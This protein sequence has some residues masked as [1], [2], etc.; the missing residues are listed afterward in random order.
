MKAK[1][2]GITSSEMAVQ[3]AALHPDYMGFVFAKSRRQVEPAEVNTFISRMREVTETLP[4]LVGVFGHTSQE[5]IEQVL[6]RV[7]LDAIQFHFPADID[8]LPAIKQQF[9]VEI[10]LTIPIPHF[11]DEE[12][13]KISIKHLLHLKGFENLEKASSHIDGV[14][15]DTHD[16]VYGGGSGKTFRW[17]LIPLVAELVDNYR[18]PL[19]AAGGLTPSNVAELKQYPLAGVDVSSGVESNGVKDI[20]KVRQFIERVRNHDESRT[21]LSLS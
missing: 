13:D 6:H 1:I 4:K 17:E 8:W 14:L 18:L 20:D 15:L 2:C 7:K 3:I 11:N 10:W 19:F 9:E 21:N 12:L 5:D 16:P